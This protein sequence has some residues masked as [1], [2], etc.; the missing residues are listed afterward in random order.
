[1]VEKNRK[2]LKQIVTTVIDKS[3]C[4]TC[5][6]YLKGDFPS[7]YLLDYIRDECG[8]CGLVKPLAPFNQWDW[9]SSPVD[10][11]LAEINKEEKDDT[12]CVDI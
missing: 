9:S 7:A 3:I 5:V 8:R 1:M 11:I 12:L 6:A 10:D 2:L 4:P